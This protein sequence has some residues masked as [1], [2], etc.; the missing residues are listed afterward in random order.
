LSNWSWTLQFLQI[1][2]QY[3]LSHQPFWCQMREKQLAGCWICY[4]QWIC[5]WG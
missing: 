3:R 5:R 2:W 4:G 1:S